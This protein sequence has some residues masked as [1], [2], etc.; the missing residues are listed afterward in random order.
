MNPRLSL[1]LVR[2]LGCG[3]QY[4]DTVTTE[5]NVDTDIECTDTLDNDSDGWNGIAIPTMLR[6]PLLSPSPLLR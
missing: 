5:S 3:E 4:D 6:C 2:P 1:L